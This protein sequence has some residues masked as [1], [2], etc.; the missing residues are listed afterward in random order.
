MNWMVILI[1]SN[2]ACIVLFILLLINYKTLDHDLKKKVHEIDE[3]NN[4]TMIKLSKLSHDI[5]TPLNAIMG[6]SFL[7]LNNVRGE[8]SPKQRQDLERISNNS[9][10]ILK[11]VEDYFDRVT[12]KINK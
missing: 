11:I 9:D 6:Y 2:I 1:I 10:R 8:L 4:N 7:L 5:R 3:Y 12:E